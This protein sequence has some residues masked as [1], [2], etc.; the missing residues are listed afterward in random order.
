MCKNIA[1]VYN[2]N[3]TIGFKKKLKEKH[4]TVG[5]IQNVNTLRNRYIES[6]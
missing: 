1:E 6:K 5:A 3:I 4:P 2:L